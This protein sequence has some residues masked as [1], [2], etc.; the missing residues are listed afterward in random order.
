MKGRHHWRGPPCSWFWRARRSMQ[1]TRGG[2]S[3]ESQVFSSPQFVQW[4][5]RKYMTGD[6]P[7]VYIYMNIYIQNIAVFIWWII[8]S[9]WWFGTFLMF[10]YIGNLIIP[11]DFHVFQRG[12][13]GPPTSYIF[14]ISGVSHQRP[15]SKID[16]GRIPLGS[17]ALWRCDGCDVQQFGWRI[18]YGNDSL[19]CDG[20]IMVHLYNGS[21][22]E[23]C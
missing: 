23:E 4:I 14:T 2:L 9:G 10:P 3:Q 13:P 5:Q 15:A 1:A 19:D 16:H 7:Y 18:A 21:L 11:T 8:I 6:M 12:G 22:I 20:L 17:G